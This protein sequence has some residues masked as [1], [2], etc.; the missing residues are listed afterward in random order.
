MAV[1]MT[2]LLVVG[3]TKGI[4]KVIAERAGATGANVS[5]M[6]RSGRWNVNLD[7]AASIARALHYS[8]EEY[9]PIT[10]LVFSQR[11]R[12]GTPWDGELAVS[13]TAT[14]YLIDHCMEDGA[15]RSIVIISSVAGRVV[16]SEQPAAYHVAK[17]GLEALV[18]YYAV[19]LGPNGIRINAIAPGA[20]VKPESRSFY[21]QHPEMTQLYAETCPLQRMGTAEDVADVALWLLSDQAS[22]LTGQTIVLDGGLSCVSQETIMRQHSVAKDLQVTQP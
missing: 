11:Y 16:V 6:G 7:N 8:K 2:H 1:A 19:T 18:R 4:G 9:G 3:G 13:L 10:Q 14:K 20:T 5:V 21:E 17:A 12:N 22:Y 15:L